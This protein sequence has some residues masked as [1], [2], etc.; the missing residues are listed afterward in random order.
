MTDPDPLAESELSRI[1]RLCDAAT[2]G[3]WT[4]W[5]EGRDH[6][7]GS[8]FIRTAGEDLELDG[9]T[10]ADYDFISS[11]RQDVPRLLEEVRALRAALARAGG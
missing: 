6:L 9:A 1:E 3:P 11:A 2:P 7:A 10:T 5:I 4:A 8:S